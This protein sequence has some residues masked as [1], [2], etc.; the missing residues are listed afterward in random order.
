MYNRSL[1]FVINPSRNTQL[2]RWLDRGSLAKQPWQMCFP[3]A[4]YI[5]LE[6]LDVKACHR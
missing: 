6:D 1:F 2:L 3:Q 5:S 4:K